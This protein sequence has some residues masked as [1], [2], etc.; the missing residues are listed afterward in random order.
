[1]STAATAGERIGRVVGIGVFSMLILALL[2]LVLWPKVVGGAIAQTTWTSQEKA[3]CDDAPGCVVNLVA[4]GVAPV[5]W[6]IAWIV[7][8]GLAVVICWSPTRWWSSRGR[9]PVEII[10]DS[11]PRW[12][13][14]H[15]VVAAFLCLLLIAPGRSNSTTWALEYLIPSALALGVAGLATLSL[16]HARATLGEAA[17]AER[18]GTSLFFDRVARTRARKTANDKDG[19]P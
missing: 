9:G 12:L 3:A 6:A 10:A 4:G 14:L 1:M 13:R 11:S 7:L 5:G 19:T 8:I 18:A 15:A 2:G 16:R 17:F